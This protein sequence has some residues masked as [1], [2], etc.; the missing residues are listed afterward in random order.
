MIPTTRTRTTRTI[1]ILLSM[2][3]PNVI[4]SSTT[5]TRLPRLPRTTITIRTTTTTS[6]SRSNNN[7]N[8]INQ[9]NN[10]NNKGGSS[11]SSSNYYHQN[12][13]VQNWVRSIHQLL[14]V[15]LPSSSQ[16][17]VDDDNNHP[18][19]G[20]HSQDWSQALEL[21]RAVRHS[22]S[23]LFPSLSSS[24]S[25]YL[26]TQQQEQ[27]SIQH[28]QFAIQLLDR[29]CLEKKNLNHT[30][31][32]STT[33]TN[34]VL[35]QG[36]LMGVL[37]TWRELLLLSLQSSSTYNENNNYSTMK[38]VYTKEK[39]Q[40]PR[41]RKKHKNHDY[42]YKKSTPLERIQVAAAVQVRQRRMT[43]A[44]QQEQAMVRIMEILNPAVM[45]LKV[46][47]YMQANL[48][49]GTMTTTSSLVGGGDPPV[50][51]PT[52]A[53]YNIILHALKQ[54]KGYGLFL[55]QQQQDNNNNNN[56]H[57]E[58]EYDH[59]ADHNNDGMIHSNQSSSSYHYPPQSQQQQ[60]RRGGDD[61]DDNPLVQACWLGEDMFQQILN[62][63]HNNNNNHKVSLS[64]SS[65]VS[66]NSSSHSPQSYHPL[67]DELTV[68]NMIE[69]W[70]QS[71]LPEA[72]QHAEAHFTQLQMWYNQQQQQEQQLLEKQQQDQTNTTTFT[73]SQSQQQHYLVPWKP[74]VHHYC[75]VMEAYSQSHGNS[76]SN[77]FLIWQSLER[78]QALYQE[79]KKQQQEQ[80][81]EL[82]NKNNDINYKNNH[83]MVISTTRICHALANCR[84]PH[85]ANIARTV[86]DDLI[87]SIVLQLQQSQIK[88][89]NNNN[90]SN[91]DYSHR[92]TNNNNNKKPPIELQHVY[93][94]VLTAYGRIGRAQEAQDLFD[95]MEQFKEELLL[96][97]SNTN[98][99]HNN[100]VIVPD[101][102]CYNALIWAHVKVGN[103]QQVEQI[104]SH[105][106]QQEMSFLSMKNKN[107]HMNNN[108]TATTLL[109]YNTWNGVLASWAESSDPQTASK[110]IAMILKRLET[111]AEREWQEEEQEEPT[112]MED[113]MSIQQQPKQP[114]RTFLPIS[115]YNTLM[116]CYARYSNMEGAQL[117]YNL[118]QWICQQQQQNNKNKNQNFQPNGETYLGLIFA[119]KNAGNAI[120]C[121]YYLRELCHL[122]RIQQEQQKEQQEQQRIV[123]TSS[124]SL[125]MLTM[126]PLHFNVAMEAWA[127]NTTTTTCPSRQ[128]QEQ[129]YSQKW[130]NAQKV[131]EIFDLMYHV[132]IQPNLVN[133]NTLLWAWARC[134]PNHHH[135][136]Q[137]DMDSKKNEQEDEEE[138][139]VECIYRQMVEQNDP[140]LQ[141]DEF[142]YNAV[143]YGLLQQQEHQE[144]KSSRNNKNNKKNLKSRS[145]RNNT[146]V[147]AERFFANVPI[148]RR[149]IEMYNTFM[150]A[151][152]RRN[153]PERV[154]SLFQELVQTMKTTTTRE[155][156][157]QQLHHQQHIVLDESNPMAEQ[158]QQVSSQ[159]QPPPP[160][161]PFSLY[162]TRLQAW[163][164]A[165]NPEKAVTV[166]QEMI[167][168]YQEGSLK[169]PPTTKG[170]NAII[171]AWLRSNR[172]NA[173]SMAEAG[174]IHMMEHG[175]Q[176]KQNQKQNQKQEINNNP[177]N[178]KNNWDHN[179]PPPPNALTFTMVISAY[180]KSSLPNA[181]DKA[182]SLLQK[183]KQLAAQAKEEDEEEEEAIG[184]NGLLQ[185]PSYNKNNNTNKNNNN[186]E[187]TTGSGI[188]SSPW[189]SGLQ[190]TFVTYTEV[191]LALLRSTTI[192]I[193][194]NN[195][196]NNNHHH[197]DHKVRNLERVRQLFMELQTKPKSF[198]FETRT[199]ELT[200]KIDQAL[201]KA[202][203]AA[204]VGH[205]QDQQ[206]QQPPPFG[207]GYQQQQQLVDNLRAEWT[208]LRSR[209]V[210]TT[211][212]T[213]MG[214]ANRI[215]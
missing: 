165:G 47:E 190:P 13:L 199:E 76:S 36:I 19:G 176:K 213:T 31:K 50:P 174:L 212:T 122:V 87:Q 17:E 196:N 2:I 114:R 208:Q 74:T 152:S 70:A 68:R 116:S 209:L 117:A 136:H 194:R 130:N 158:R 193:D 180:A 34:F 38:N 80:D 151:C 98:C 55:I 95:S 198:W 110:H 63:H 121:E 161:P 123:P 139:I 71:G 42:G 132:Q 167:V 145:S 201:Q 51:P 16:N 137:Q 149:N 10:N 78:I 143:L 52:V 21:L 9:N 118:F 66:S 33:R 205:A 125:E 173:A 153:E 23:L 54:G 155:Q 41:L 181:G 124:S 103:S 53:P 148:E 108:H 48:V 100:F 187:S 49:T 40:Q 147:R 133:Y 29:L 142:T 46:Q 72:P 182:W 135:E 64:P 14:L 39:Q 197:V 169:E 195:N 89:Y 90:Q 162:V 62:N 128:Q 131:Q 28:L 171:H 4:V 163:S 160:R 102:I 140:Y 22:S 168:G 105:M 60:R 83:D 172:P 204:T 88:N 84:H 214:G 150:T 178:D 112:T 20:F 185:I 107:N 67:P 184:R 188:A 45:F 65:F 126:D 192:R 177:N 58:E 115:A 113:S 120:Q 159:P 37:V 96:L 210:N 111:L 35:E 200:I 146:F 27:E 175:F 183:L 109:D 91:Q 26:H 156:Q 82:Y 57:Y 202:N 166:L 1:P 7:N 134:V 144:Q 127:K 73:N 59:H 206:Q 207:G 93:S 75:A 97:D 215:C 12:D 170:F 86:L 164:K 92:I 32:N 119:Y 186:N 43:G 106:I 44:A 104:V 11:G 129:E 77:Q 94:A 6:S 69:L 191:I 157:Q 24:S 138:L 61:Y 56:T 101:V 85:A 141:P 179:I 189:Q 79:M 81:E 211:T 3:H 5:T 15:P 203:V 25:S 8:A 18:N 30:K 154:E 99:N